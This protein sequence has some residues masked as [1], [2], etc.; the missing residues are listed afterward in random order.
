MMRKHI[1]SVSSKVRKNWTRLPLLV[2]AVLTGFVVST[3]GVVSW[4][5]IGTLVPMP[6][7]F[8][9]MFGFLGAYL[10]YFSGH[11]GPKIRRNARAV[12]FR[13]L[14][15]PRRV[16][17]LSLF[18][19]ALIV[20]IEQ[21]GLV[22]TFRI[23]EFPADKFLQEYGFIE[24]IPTWAGWL[25]IIMISAVAGICEEV[26]FRGYMQVPLE[27]HYSPLVSIS[28]VSVVFVL[29]HLHQAWSGPIIIHIFFIS[30]LFGSIAYYSGSLIP[31]IIAHF[32]MDICNFSFWWT[33]LGGQF[34]RK[35]L[36][37]T[38]IDSHFILWSLAWILSVILF[39]ITIRKIGQ[40]NQTIKQRRPAI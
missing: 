39:I 26:G 31:G 3:V 17:L 35:P 32:I 1:K 10:R 28:L 9:V 24:S 40:Q 4:P 12:R 33:D 19:V 23:M 8:I 27:K 38:G 37:Q 22:V 25:V 6:W 21:S 18:A 11:W 34:N 7:A 14:I 15:L 36:H 13:S 2:K 20:L 5:L 30:V 16:W 29:V